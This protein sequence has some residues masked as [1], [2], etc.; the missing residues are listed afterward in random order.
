[1]VFFSSTQDIGVDG[2]VLTLLSKENVGWGSVSQ[3]IGQYFGVFISSSFFINLNSIK[4][5]NDYIFST[6]Q[7]VP[8]LTA[9]QFFLFFAFFIFIINFFIHFYVEEKEN[10]EENTNESF[11]DVLKSFKG[12]LTNNNLKY[13]IFFEIFWKL[14]FAVVFSSADLKLVKAGFPKESLSYISALI[15]PLNFSASFLV[16]KYV[17]RG[18]EMNVFWICY[19][20]KFLDNIFM[21]FIIKNYTK[22]NESIVIFFYILSAIIGTIYGTV[23]FVNSGAFKNRICDEKIGGTFLTLLNSVSNFGGQF[24]TSLFFYLMD[25]FTYD[26]LAIFGWAYIVLFFVF[27]FKKVISL[28]TKKDSDWKVILSENKKD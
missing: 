7:I 11:L 9:K 18:S 1:M 17:K 14:G 24:S 10:L 27:N 6:P 19:I 23:I 13:Y 3:S 21:Y 28:Q 2:W 5:C 16:G 20:F 15:I 22:E 25:F 8:L 4:F 26:Y 12:F